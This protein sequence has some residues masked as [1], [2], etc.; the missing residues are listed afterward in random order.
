MEY[1]KVSQEEGLLG[2]HSQYQHPRP[3]REPLFRR[4]LPYGY[5]I[6]FTLS[7]CLNGLLLSD[8]SRASNPVASSQS[9]PRPGLSDLPAGR[10]LSNESDIS[11]NSW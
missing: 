3:Q 8:R 10:K 9:F 4:A 2:E 7:I 6:L 1:E 5:L 11:P